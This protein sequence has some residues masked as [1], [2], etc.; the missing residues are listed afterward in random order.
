MLHTVKSLHYR[1]ANYLALKLLHLTNWYCNNNTLF[2]I[3]FQLSRILCYWMMH[4]FCP[5]LLVCFSEDTLR[6]R[7]FSVDLYLKQSAPTLI[8][9]LFGVC[10]WFPVSYY[11][12]VWQYNLLCTTLNVSLFIITAPLFPRIANIWYIWLRKCCVTLYL[13]MRL[14]SPG[15]A[16]LR[17]SCDSVYIRGVFDFVLQTETFFVHPQ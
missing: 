8:K 13:L 14:S 1:T 5:N 12:F 2:V 6:E 7:W 11:L 3:C 10:L 17:T 15:A 16:H 9:T 4:F